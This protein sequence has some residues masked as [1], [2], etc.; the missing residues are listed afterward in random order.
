[1]WHQLSWSH[2][3]LL[4]VLD[5]IEEINFYS[6]TSVEQLYTVRQL[7]NIIKSKEYERLDKK[8]KLKLINAEKLEVKD[9]I[10]N[11]IVINNKNKYENITEKIL[12]KIIL[13]DIPSFLKELG[14]GFTFI[15]YEY[16][17]KL[18]DTY[19]H[20]DLLLYNIK[21]KC[22]VVIEL[23]ITEL[24]KKH[25]GQIK[26]YMNYIDKNIK[27]IDEDKT[28]GIIICKRNNKYIIEYCSDEKIISKEYKVM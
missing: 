15:D 3:K 10:P 26:T 6:K 16:K 20:I 25:I 5:T 4:I 11:P 2:Y 27:T 8:T 24:R 19:N 14:N 23:K 17:I 22:Y 7:Q 12:Q 13:E 18:G 21:Y 28:I 1:M 9:L